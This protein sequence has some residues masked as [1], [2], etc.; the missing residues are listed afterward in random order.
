[1]AI[2]S[3]L[4]SLNINNN[5]DKHDAIFWYLIFYGGFCG[6]RHRQITQMYVLLESIT[7]YS[8]VESTFEKRFESENPQ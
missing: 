7:G 2:L 1:M 4:F 6:L 5:I 3:K 8:I